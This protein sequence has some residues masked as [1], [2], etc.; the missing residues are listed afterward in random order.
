MR[1]FNVRLAAILLA[2]VLVLGVG[3]GFLHSYQLRSNAIFFLNESKNAEKRAAN[4]EKDNDAALKEKSL[5]E[6]IRYLKSYVTLNPGGYEAKEQLGILLADQAQK[7]DVVTDRQTFGQA[8]G[9]LE[10]TVRMSPDRIEGRRRL[11]KMSMIMG[12]YQDAKD[13]LER[14]LLIKFPKDPELLEQLGQCQAG[15]GRNDLAVQAYKKSIACGPHQLTAYVKL[16]NLL[17]SQLSKPDEADQWI[18]YLV[19]VNPKSAKAHYYRS[20]YLGTVHRND[21]AIAEAA[22]ALELAPDDADILLQAAICNIAKQRYDKARE[23]LVHG[24][25]VHPTNVFMP[26]LLSDIELHAGNRDQAIAVLQNGVK[27]TDRNPWLL[28]HLANLLIDANKLEDSQQI[29]DELRKRGY[30][31]SMIDYVKARLELAQGIGGPPW[32]ALRTCAAR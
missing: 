20:R 5:K 7:G 26:K 12:R 25:K 27:A 4:A 23:C 16:A 29:L 22:K 1:V 15:L 32:R 21:E 10:N 3:V 2:I 6:A 19:K 31:K 8:Y 28:W 24:I 11:V 18:D 9:L 30:R 13:H 17:R 14:F